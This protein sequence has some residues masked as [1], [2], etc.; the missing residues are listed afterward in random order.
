MLDTWDVCT[1]LCSS[2]SYCQIQ[3]QILFQIQIHGQ[4]ILRQLNRYGSLG[5]EVREVLLPMRHLFSALLRIRALNMG[6]YCDM[7]RRV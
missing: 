6:C 1:L 4:A 7:A 5:K 2:L 3:S